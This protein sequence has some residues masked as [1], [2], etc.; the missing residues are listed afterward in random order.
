MSIYKK[1]CPPTLTVFDS[2]PA[3]GSGWR[4]DLYANTIAHERARGAIKRYTAAAAESGGGG[5]EGSDGSGGG[6]GS[7]SL[8]LLR[9]LAGSVP[10]GGGGGGGTAASAALEQLAASTPP[11][12]R[13]KA[14][15]ERLTAAR[16]VVAAASAA[17]SDGGGGG[18]S[19]GG[20]NPSQ[21]RAVE[22]ALGRTLTL[23][24]GWVGDGVRGYTLGWGVLKEGFVSVGWTGELEASS[25]CAGTGHGAG[26]RRL[27]FAAC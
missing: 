17:A 3:Q 24:Q 8:Q 13:G 7:S 14:G 20:L 19:K 26:I 18:G 21:A 1:P 23:W 10:G 5:E 9:A 11:W 27:P 2:K 12:L 16:R 25:S 15:R 22:A 6:G 4:L